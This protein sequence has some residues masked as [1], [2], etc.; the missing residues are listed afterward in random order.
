MEP[1]NIQ[2]V[3]LDK[4]DMPSKVEYLRLMRLVQL[5]RAEIEQQHI[6]Q[7]HFLIEQM[8]LMRLVQLQRAE[9]EQSHIEQQHFLIKQM[10]LK[11]Q[12]DTSQINQSQIISDINQL[13]SNV[14]YSQ[15]LHPP[16]EE[17]I[18]SQPP[19][20]IPTSAQMEQLRGGTSLQIE[21]IHVI[22]QTYVYQPEIGQPQLSS[23]YIKYSNFYYNRPFVF[24]RYLRTVNTT[25]YFTNIIHEIEECCKV[26]IQ[27]CSIP[28][29]TLGIITCY[30]GCFEIIP[31]IAKCNIKCCKDICIIFSTIISCIIL[32]LLPILFMI[33]GTKNPISIINISSNIWVIIEGISHISYIII[34]TILNHYLKKIMNAIYDDYST[35]N[36]YLNIINRIQNVKICILFCKIIWTFLGIAFLVNSNSN[37]TFILIIIDIV[38]V[39]TIQ[40]IGIFLHL[41]LTGSSSCIKN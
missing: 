37:I 40:L 22:Q 4:V 18:D 25:E 30:V 16:T 28:C 11:S 7:Q 19:Q 23:K 14:T 29:F 41:S 21:P 24:N 17:L 1:S 34:L 3:Y 33:Y 9:I 36:K 32:L 10:R 5:Q 6:E 15:L 39:N 31:F 8:R 2:T 27:H 13:E 12:I 35:I 38:L 20:L 26:F